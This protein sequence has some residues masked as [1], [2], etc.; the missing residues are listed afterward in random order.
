MTGRNSDSSPELLVG[1]SGLPNFEGQR[2]A[3]RS[4]PFFVKDYAHESS[5]RGTV[6]AII[7]M[8]LKR[9]NGSAALSKCTRWG[10]ST[11]RPSS[12]SRSTCG[13]RGA[14]GTKTTATRLG[15]RR[16]VRYH[17]RWDAKLTDSFHSLISL[18][19]SF[20]KF[21]NC[22]LDSF[23]SCVLRISSTELTLYCSKGPF[24]FPLNMRNAL[25]WALTHCLMSS[26][27]A[28]SEVISKFAEFQ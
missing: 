6:L 17:F 5:R 11:V 27:S 15:G 21:W 9:V 19:I 13:I 12:S 1:S 7:L 24:G 18:I 2:A 8:S 26:N 10:G 14:N 16:Q 20:I 28:V 25:C 4:E 3:E 23:P 22:N